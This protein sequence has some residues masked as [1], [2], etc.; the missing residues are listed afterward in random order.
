[1]IRNIFDDL[2][3]SPG[4][5]RGVSRE[6]DS[7]QNLPSSPGDVQ[8]VS[9]KGERQKNK[10]SDFS[11]CSDKT[12][13]TL[14]SMLSK[15]DKNFETLNASIA[16]MV[17]LFSANAEAQTDQ[18]G[19][20]KRKADSDV[21]SLIPP[22][23][24]GALMRSDNKRRKVTSGEVESETNS[25]C[26]YTNLLEDINSEESD[27]ESENELGSVF[28]QYVGMF[29]NEEK[30]GKPVS[31]K[32]ADTVERSLKKCIRLSDDVTK[33]LDKE[34][35]RPENCPTL[36]VPEVNR[37]VWEVVKKDK[38]IKQRERQLQKILG[39]VSKSMIPVL[40]LTDSF[41]STKSRQ[42]I[43]LKACVIQS[44]DALSLM[45]QAY[46][47]LNI[48]RRQNIKPAINSQYHDVCH[49]DNPVTTK[50]FGDDWNKQMKELK[51]SKNLKISWK[52]VYKDHR[53]RFNSA[54]KHIK[55][56][57]KQYEKP[58]RPWKFNRMGTKKKNN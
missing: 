28:G 36:R 57:Y 17:S 41:L 1:M 26:D 46:T 14:Y 38:W 44:T 49:Q 27:C 4:T 11:D 39:Y 33:R 43:D 6:G 21:S 42:T 35:A 53:N 16:K 54:S 2:P 45:S 51:E 3:S 22:S 24:T 13:E 30:T 37:E 25:V 31:Q 9:E 20:A 10:S 18:C 19:P 29:D 40:R 7:A 58:S 32:L 8:G 50:L 23:G 48:Y 5:D 15:Q 52:D 12:T 34:Y 56:N 47:G 55:S